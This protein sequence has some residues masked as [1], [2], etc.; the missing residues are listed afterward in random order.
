MSQST[1]LEEP[2]KLQLYVYGAATPNSILAV[3]NLEAI[4]RNQPPGRLQIEVIDISASP[5]KALADGIL[6]T[7][8]LVKLSPL[9]TVQ[10]IGNLSE[11]SIVLKALGLLITRDEDG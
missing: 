10:I 5:F 9:P 2:I 7:P 4:R 3:N 11:T 1:P 8:T 6:V